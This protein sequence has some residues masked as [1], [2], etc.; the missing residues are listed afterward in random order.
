MLIALEIAFRRGHG[1]REMTELLSLQIEH[2]NFGDSPVFF[3]TG[4]KDV[5][6]LSERL[7]VVKSK[8]KKPRTIPMTPRV[9]TKLLSVIQGRTEGPVFSSPRTGA[10]L[11]GIKRGFKRACELA[12]IPHG[13]TTPG[14]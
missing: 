7:L 14:G 5:E 1:M 4:S 3:N 11:V 9:R 2:V 6:V 8:N 12:G 10:S 13:Q